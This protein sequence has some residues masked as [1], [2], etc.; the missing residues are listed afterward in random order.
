MI[1]TGKSREEIESKAKERIA[2]YL[3]VTP[4]ETEEKTDIEFF[5]TVGE[6]GPLDLTFT[7]DCTVRIK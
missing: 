6:E 7:A 1:V 5:I 2:K 4:E 3:S